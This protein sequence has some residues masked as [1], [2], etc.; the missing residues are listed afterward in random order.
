MIP[1]DFED[2]DGKPGGSYLLD[3][4]IKRIG[5]TFTSLA[6]AVTNEHVVTVTFAAATTDTIVRHGLSGPPVTWEVVDI[7]DN[8]VIWRSPTVS[9]RRDLIIL[10]ASSPVTA[11]VRFS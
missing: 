9:A 6:R 11:K 3:R 5:D 4:L 1:F 8:A 2:T 10:Q 7:T